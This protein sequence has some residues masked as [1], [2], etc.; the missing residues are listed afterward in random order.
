[1]GKGGEE[2]LDKIRVSLLSVTPHSPHSSACAVLSVR[3]LS[4]NMWGRHLPQTMHIINR[5]SILDE[6]PRR[7][8]SQSLIPKSVVLFLTLHVLPQHTP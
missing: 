3:C 2:A 5:M 6:I 7:P 1:M 4:L 8:N